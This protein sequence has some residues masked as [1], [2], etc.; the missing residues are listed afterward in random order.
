MA[1]LRLNGGAFLFLPCVFDQFPTFL[2]VQDALR[3]QGN[4]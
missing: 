1:W 3:D 2:I 4:S